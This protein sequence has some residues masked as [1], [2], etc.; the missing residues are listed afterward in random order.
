MLLSFAWRRVGSVATAALLA[1]AG[2]VGEGL[3]AGLGFEQL[4]AL[5]VVREAVISPDG[6]QI[7]YALEVP[8]RPGVDT[9]GP[10]WRELHV[11]AA[12][13][14]P[15][16][17][18][19]GG[20]VKVSTVRF[21]PD[22]S[23]I[24]YLA[25]RGDDEQ[26][27]LWVIPLAGGESRRMLGF[28]TA[29][30]D[31]RISPD[32]ST[33]AFIAAEPEA[34]AR[35]KAREAGFTQEIFE[36]DWAPTRVWLAP[37]PAVAPTVVDPAAVTGAAAEPRAL[38]LDGSA[39]HVR[40]SPDG[41]R[42]AVDLAPRPLVDDEYM[43]RR[44]HVVD[45][46]TGEVVARLD[47]PGKLGDFDFSP[48]G[49]QLAMI[50][51]AD[52]ND[53]SAG[54]LLVAPAAGGA[55]RDVLPALAGDVAAFAWQD[56]AT[57]MFL[58]DEGEESRFAEVDLASGAVKTHASSTGGGALRAPILSGLSLAADGRRAALVGDS[59]SHPAEVFVI[60]HGDPAPRRL[61]DSNPWLA[62]VE[63]ARQEVF[64]YQARD[65]LPLRGVL[66]RPLAAPAGPA[67]LLLMVH[68]GPEAHRSNG[69]VSS[70]GS[71][72]Q[73][74][75]ARGY[76]VYFPNYRGSTGRG[77]A[78]SKLGQGDAAGAEFDDLVDAVDALIAAGVADRDRVG[79]TGGSYGGY[80]TAWCATR[81]SERF[82]A[83][84]MF[85][86]ISNEISKGLTTEIPVEDREV[87]TL[88]DPWT[89]WQLRLERSPIFHAESSRTALL[90]AG[91]TAD[92]RVHPAQS[93]QLY[94]AL[95]LLGR[96]PVRYVRYPGEGHGNARAAARDD[97]AR[98]LMRWMDHFVMEGRSELPP[99]ELASGAAAAAPDEEG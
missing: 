64:A 70:Y 81:H 90:I 29:I 32:G 67:P 28:T 55:L 76:A 35:T 42:L 52:R 99:W 23:L 77:V 1:A 7:A 39:F 33:V 46:A 17:V 65:G 11:V 89:K 24:T 80:A 48:D 93:L 45:A 82:K 63:L 13:G 86:G 51:A 49:R 50:S 47:N 20:E 85:V 18:Y 56:A 25:T 78:F 44:V 69:W 72:A 12:A 95:K 58:A 6:S 88:A 87:H 22:G 5:R 61:S 97:Y 27:A 21:S 59:P 75:A 15:D 9:D 37:L 3:A 36:E 79:I 43:E 26:A 84:V 91:G 74:A 62:A 60:C 98:R 8:R 40:F 31:Y 14:G 54:R 53:P 16:R 94:R 92:S 57:L 34:E 71:P 2:L 73:I 30:S 19:V 96:A 68:G 83:G 4:A 38:A 10:A 41:A 66:L